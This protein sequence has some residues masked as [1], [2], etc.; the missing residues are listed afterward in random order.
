MSFED[1]VQTEASI[2]GVT[3]VR[4]LYASSCLAEQSVSQ[5]LSGM[6]RTSLS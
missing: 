3:H 1:A 4:P 5:T 6:S 2:A